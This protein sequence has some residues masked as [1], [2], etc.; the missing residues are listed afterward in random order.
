[1]KHLFSIIMI[2]VLIMTIFSCTR[3][4]EFDEN[5]IR[6]SIDKANAQ[7]CEVMKNGDISGIL[8]IYTD[9]ATII[10]PGGEIVKGK[11]NIQKVYEGI[12]KGGLKEI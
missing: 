12:L 9:D 8:E 4:N 11:Q 7:Y 1:M 6:Q 10:P 2:L 3:Q 5:Q